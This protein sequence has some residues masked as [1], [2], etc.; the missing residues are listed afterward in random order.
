MATPQNAQRNQR[1]SR[2]LSV[3]LLV[4]GGVAILIG[5]HNFAI[6]A[7]GLALVLASVYLIQASKVRNRSGLPLAGGEVNNPNVTGGPGRLL[8]IASVSL[9]PVLVCAW[10]LLHLDAANGGQ[11]VWPVYVFAGVALVCAVVWSLLG[12]KVFGRAGS[13]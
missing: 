3:I 6:R 1:G 4:L 10:Y 9:V 2:I 13:G 12:A 8:W 7:V 11:E 5:S